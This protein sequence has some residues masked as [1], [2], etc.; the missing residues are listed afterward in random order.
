MKY[1]AMAE[2]VTG[3]R[4]TMVTLA[5][6]LCVAN[7]D[8]V[9][10]NAT[11]LKTTIR[12]K[13]EGVRVL[14]PG[15]AILPMKVVGEL[16]KKI[17]VSPFTVEV[18]DLKGTIV[19]GRSR[20]A[21]TTYPNGD[22]PD[23]P[24][25]RPDL[26]EDFARVSAGDLARAIA[27]GSIAGAPND[28]FPKYLSGGLIQ[29]ISGEL[30]VVAT[31]GRRLSLSKTMCKGEPTEALTRE[32]LLPLTS[33]SEYE[34]IL[35]GFQPDQEVEIRQDG[36]VTYFNLPGV[37]YSMRCI[38]SRFPNY[39]RILGNTSSTQLQA[40]RQSL[41]QALDR[42]NIVVGDN[43]RVVVL[44]LSP[45]ASV[46]MTG[47]APELGEANE[48]IDANINGEPLRV[49]F[50]VG[51]LLTGIKAFHSSEV[52]LSFNGAEGQMI[53][54]RPGS[55]DFIYMLMPIKLKSAEGD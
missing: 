43:S 7:E 51:Y 36:S 25:P 26:A 24:S 38:D 11:D 50:N 32:I 49:A 54:T 1:W 10:L 5:S 28:D 23:L 2:R 35:S 15:T 19:A 27:E 18:K 47:R 31:D 29:V 8:G 16:F 41:L 44:K 34:R 14:E 3:N 53:I 45:G 22:F 30:R 13:A 21:F 9:V 33:L 40:D 37:Q 6:I 17:P 46:D 39:E 55:D 20:Y 48:S 52:C 4:S 12:V 42:V